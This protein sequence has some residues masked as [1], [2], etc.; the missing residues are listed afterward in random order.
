MRLAD[1]LEHDERLEAL[2]A[3]LRARPGAEVD[4]T[5]LE[6]ISNIASRRCVPLVPASLLND[7]P[8][9]CQMAWCAAGTHRGHRKCA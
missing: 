9:A 2:L 5:V 1:R 4:A 6:D 3:G 7:H 8:Q